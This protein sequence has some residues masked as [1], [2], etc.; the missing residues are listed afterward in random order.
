VIMSSR[1]GRGGA[2]G[3]LALI[4]VDERAL[5]IPVDDVVP[6]FATGARV[7]LLAGDRWVARDG[8][9]V[10]TAEQAITVAVDED[11]APDVAVAILEG[12]I[13]LALVSP[14]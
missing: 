12:T 1:L 8:V 9:V 14:G 4:G 5:V 3:P 6:A 13:S 7:D 10:E 11:D 2:T